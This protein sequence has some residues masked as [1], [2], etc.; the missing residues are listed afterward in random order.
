MISKQDNDSA[1]L[2]GG[3]FLQSY[4]EV[5]HLADLRPAIGKIPRLNEGCV[6]P[7]PF[8]IG[9]QQTRLPQDGDEGIE[10]SVYIADGN[11]PR[12]RGRPFLGGS[13]DSQRDRKST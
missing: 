13:Q 4:Q 9:S 2:A 11:Y 8:V 3:V 7:C 1:A 12:R 5:H 10:I 6:R